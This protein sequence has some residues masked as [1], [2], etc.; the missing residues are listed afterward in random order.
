MTEPEAANR[1]MRLAKEIAK[2]NRLY[3]ILRAR[4]VV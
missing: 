2:H 1:L 3:H 4:V